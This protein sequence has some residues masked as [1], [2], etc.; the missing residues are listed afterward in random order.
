[1]ADTEE[2]TPLADGVSRRDALK[3]LGA[4]ASLPILESLPNGELVAQTKPAAAPAA[5]APSQP[6]RLS[7][8][9]RGTASDPDLLRPKKDWPAPVPTLRSI[10]MPTC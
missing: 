6:Q 7:S 5:A 8:G 4:A 3:V 9:P 1:M 10:R 2:G